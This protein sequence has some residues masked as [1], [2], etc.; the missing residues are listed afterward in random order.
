M[1]YFGNTLP[2]RGQGIT[3]LPAPEV[4]HILSSVYPIVDHFF[5]GEWITFFLTIAPGPTTIPR[6][7]V[8]PSN[9]S[10]LTLTYNL[11]GEN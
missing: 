9:R 4:D 1:V 8:K 11:D 7:P 5:P 10:I 3:T 6:R 2:P